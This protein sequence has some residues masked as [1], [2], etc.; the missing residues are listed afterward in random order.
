MFVS[1]DGCTVYVVLCIIG[2]YVVC[3][4]CLYGLVCLYGMVWYGMYGMYVF[5]Y[6]MYVCM[7]SMV[8]YA[9]MVCMHV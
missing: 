4:V 2:I 8:W 6:G 1:M 5:M 3:M 7:Y 9:C